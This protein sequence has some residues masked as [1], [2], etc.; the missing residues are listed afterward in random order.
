ME[1]GML[2]KM[3]KR[4]IF[5]LILFLSFQIQAQEKEIETPT[6]PSGEEAR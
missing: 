5:G 4:S 6:T 3:L 1:T 2:L